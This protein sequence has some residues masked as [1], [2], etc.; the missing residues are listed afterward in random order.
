MPRVPL[1]I[2]LLDV[3]S[4]SQ[5]CWTVNACAHAT[6]RGFCSQRCH[7]KGRQHLV[8]KVTRLASAWRHEPSDQWAQAHHAGDDAPPP[9][10]F[11]AVRA[12]EAP[13]VAAQS[14]LITRTTHYREK[15]RVLQEGRDAAAEE[16]EGDE[17]LRLDLEDD[18]EEYFAKRDEERKAEALLEQQDRAQMDQIRKKLKVRLAVR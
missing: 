10:P 1:R 5:R 15:L 8:V 13:A 16:A 4:L 7:G 2:T 17:E 11:T 18:E 12:L 14:Q 9:L 6:S 3:Y